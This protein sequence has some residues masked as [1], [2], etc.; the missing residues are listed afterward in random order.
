MRKM[1][2]IEA[3][4]IFLLYGGL[5][6]TIIESQVIAHVRTM[7]KEGVDIEVW[8]Y[9]VTR[10]C[11]LNAKGKFKKLSNQNIPQNI[12]IKIF[13]G[14]RPALPFSELLNALLLNYHLTKEKSNPSFMRC[15][16][17]YSASVAGIL[18][19]M[20]NFRLIWDCRG[21]SEAEF[22]LK[23]RQWK[24]IKQAFSFLKLCTIRM[25]LFWASKQADEAI[26]V[27]ESLKE[28]HA[29][30]SR[31]YRSYVISSVADSKYFHF[32]SSL[33]ANMRKQLNFSNSDKVVIY[34][35]S[36]AVW[37]CFK[38]T[39]YLIKTFINKDPCFKGII[40]SPDVEIVQ[41]FLRDC[42][43]ESLF[44]ISVSLTEVNAYLNAA[45]FAFLLRRPGPVNRVASPVK[46]AEYC[47][48]GLPIIMTNAIKQSYH[49]GNQ[50]GNTISYEFDQELELPEPFTDAERHQVSN[51]AKK[52]L[53]HET[54]LD[55]HLEIY[56]HR[57]LRTQ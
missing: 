19:L 53:S 35:G 43:E 15:R 23:K 13:R 55:K 28:V 48:A 54:V 21:D 12:P 14:F 52:V 39:A 25:R 57:E 37:Q 30:R 4:G 16:T 17:E 3:K 20:R 40:L 31:R 8:F 46:F 34:S 24:G 47:F 41:E 26:F 27:S 10:E 38:E 49:L 5:P 45:D 11:F 2:K 32:D 42:S 44:C 56:R 7:R 1:N 6:K 50:F 29:K 9:C 51:R 22:L 33:R 36:L 18:K